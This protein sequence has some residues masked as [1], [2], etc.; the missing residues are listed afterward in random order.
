M[1]LTVI[2]VIIIQLTPI[3]VIGKGE[4][5]GNC[6]KIDFFGQFE[7]GLSVFVSGC[8]GIHSNTGFQLSWYPEASQK[9]IFRT[10]LSP[11]CPFAFS[12]SFWDIENLYVCS[13]V[14]MSRNLLKPRF[15]NVCLCFQQSCFAISTSSMCLC[16]RMSKFCVICGKLC[17]FLVKTAAKNLKK[18]Q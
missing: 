1:F 6:S 10:N 17:F 13:S 2:N 14:Q 8:L 12:G 3:S 7:S 5:C 11:D 18:Y 9:Q 15:L 16:V 4:M